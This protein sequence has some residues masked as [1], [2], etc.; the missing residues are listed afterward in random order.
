MPCGILLALLIDYFVYRRIK[1]SGY[2]VELLDNPFP[3]DFWRVVVSI[4]L[5]PLS[6]LVGSE[7]LV[8]F[9]GERVDMFGMIFG[10][11]KGTEEL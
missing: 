10:S 5:I 3:S 7:V 8:Y 4:V 2:W 1:E 9:T 11:V 6:I